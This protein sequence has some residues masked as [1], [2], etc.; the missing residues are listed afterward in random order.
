MQISEWTH[1]LY[2]ATFVCDKTISTVENAIK[3]NCKC[4]YVFS[5]SLLSATSPFEGN[6]S[7][8][9]KCAY[10]SSAYF[11][12]I[13]MKICC[14]LNGERK[15]RVGGEREGQRLYTEEAKGGEIIKSRGAEERRGKSGRCN[16]NMVCGGVFTVQIKVFLQHTAG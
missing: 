15:R 9:G 7:L 14:Q 13:R 5:H 11:F 3:L 16:R 4:N 10:C 8:V 2:N 1:S 6:T 12:Y